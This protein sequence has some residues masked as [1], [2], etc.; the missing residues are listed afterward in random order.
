MLGKI[1]YVFTALS[2]FLHIFPTAV[3]VVGWVSFLWT[4]VTQVQNNA[5]RANTTGKFGRNHVL[6]CIKSIKCH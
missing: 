4:R 3:S 5:G 1:N 6:K 2:N